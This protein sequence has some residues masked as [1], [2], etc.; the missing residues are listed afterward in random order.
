MPG[1]RL[2]SYALAF[3]VTAVIGPFT[4]RATAQEP[5]FEP[6][7]I[8]RQVQLRLHGAPEEILP[9][10]SPEGRHRLAGPRP[11]DQEIVFRG[12]DDSLSGSM[13]RT[14][15]REG[16]HADAWDV[17][18]HVDQEARTMRRVHFEPG[19]ELLV[20][21]IRLDAGGNG[22]TVATI[23]WRVVGLSERGNAAVQRFMDDYF[24]ASM[25]RLEATI[26]AFLEEGRG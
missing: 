1:C 13:M 20:E 6:L 22:G 7:R 16:G 12:L 4:G 17:I 10:L 18:A 15:H 9:L 8:E 5:S 19:T 21:D 11:V 2:A 24:E 3:M 14:V 25:E 26:N 23:N